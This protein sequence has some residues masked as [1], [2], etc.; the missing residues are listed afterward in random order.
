MSC[1][2]LP[3]RKRFFRPC[4][5]RIPNR[6]RLWRERHREIQF[7]HRLYHLIQNLTFIFGATRHY[8]CDN[9]EKTVIR[10]R[11]R[12]DA[13]DLPALSSIEE[14]V[15]KRLHDAVEF[16]NHLHRNQCPACIHDAR[17]Q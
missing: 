4:A 8:G 1:Q 9:I 10:I 3:L 5:L 2:F 13:Q 12:I 17:E 11:S 6:F 7:F 14:N 15:T 16:L